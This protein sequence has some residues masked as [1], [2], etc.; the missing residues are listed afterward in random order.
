MGTG[1]SQLIGSFVG[2]L[3]T[4]WLMWFTPSPE[5]LKGSTNI[6]NLDNEPEVRGVS[7]SV[8][9]KIGR[10][11]L[12]WLLIAAMWV[13]FVLALVWHIL[14]IVCGWIVA[15]VYPPKK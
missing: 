9:M 4:A 6:K 5:P 7:G 15:W 8:L 2:M 13:G 1:E 11:P 14:S 3:I 12:V 10:G